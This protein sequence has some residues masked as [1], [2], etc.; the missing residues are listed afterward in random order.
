[1]DLIG[2][3]IAFI[4]TTISNWLGSSDLIRDVKRGFKSLKD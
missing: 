1:M 2:K 4:M 3:I